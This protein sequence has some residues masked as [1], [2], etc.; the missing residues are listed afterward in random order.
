[1]SRLNV[2]VDRQTLIARKERKILHLRDE[3]LRLNDKA[4]KISG[5]LKQKR[6]SEKS[7]RVAGGRIITHHA[8]HDV[9]V[10]KRPSDRYQDIR[11]YTNVDQDCWRYDQLRDW[12]N[13]Y[14]PAKEDRYEFNGTQSGYTVKA[15]A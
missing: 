9:D 10:T 12:F 2:P 14:A 11:A 8:A 6:T 13:T 4:S 5:D 1:M 15:D 7:L 3:I